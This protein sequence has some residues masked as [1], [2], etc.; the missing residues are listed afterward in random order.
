MTNAYDDLLFNAGQR[1]AGGT[2]VDAGTFAALRKAHRAA[3]SNGD[4][5]AVGPEP[6]IVS[7]GLMQ[8]T[9]PTAQRLGYYG[10]WGD[11]ATQTGGLYDPAIAIPLAGQLVRSN[12]LGAR[13]DVDVAI[14]AD[15][16][17]LAR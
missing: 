16:E 6:T 10:P 1:F 17:G 14:A 15:N 2:G 13:G 11:D 4:P 9:V 5:Q 8:I 12:L 7:R 3:E